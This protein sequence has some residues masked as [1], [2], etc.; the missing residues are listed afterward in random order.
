MYSKVLC[1][2]KKLYLERNGYIY[3]KQ[4]KDFQ[5]G[6]IILAVVTPWEDIAN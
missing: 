5:S 4:E 2:K 1:K 3:V 6:S